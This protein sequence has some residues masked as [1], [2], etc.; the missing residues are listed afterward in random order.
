[1]RKRVC[2]AVFFSA[3]F[4]LPLWGVTI[5]VPGDYPTIQEGLNAAQTGDTVL[6][7]PGTYVE[8]IVWPSLDGIVLIS[9]EGAD[10]TI[11]D[12]NG[13]G[14]VITFPNFAF[15]QTTTIFGFT[16][17][18]GKLGTN[19]YGAG[20]YINGSPYIFEN[21][22]QRNIA[23]DTSSTSR[24]YGGGIYCNGAGTPLILANVIR[25][26]VVQ[27]SI[28]NYGG[29]IYVDDD[30]SAVIIGNTIE[31][32]SA[33]GGYYNYGA[34]I[35]CAIGSSPD[36]RHNII[37][38]N[39][40]YQGDRGHGVGIYVADDS[41]PYILSN[42]IY[43]N[44]AQSG[45]WNYGA[46]MLLNSGATVFNNTIAENKC[47]GGNWRYGGGI[48]LYDSTQTIGN[49]IVVNNT[50][51][52]GGGIYASTNGHA[53]LLNNDVWNN[54]G[55]NYSGIAPGANDISLDPLFVTGPLGNFY[56]SQIAAG[57]GQDSPCVD[58]GFASAES[59]ELN[60]YTTR[61]DTIPDSGMVDLGY[62]YP[63]SYYVT[64]EEQKAVTPT[65][66]F[67]VFPSL[68]SSSYR[69]QLMLDSNKYV[70]VHIFDEAGRLQRILFNGKLA[71]GKHYWTWNSL[72]K[73]GNRLPSGT[74]FFIVRVG[75]YKT[76]SK[77]VILL[78]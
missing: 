46:G 77:K 16:I 23:S 54:T 22:I 65:S 59:L 62:H 72:D 57:Q 27:S 49:N 52:S 26:N 20:L 67:Q 25:G 73:N 21:I 47:T 63:T 19:V 45:L 35:Y 6:V 43:N 15:T 30:N 42:L 17:Q 36:I 66:L 50:A 1:M 41:Y 14:R 60:T 11:I 48:F 8:N 61:T 32:D 39:V 12:G 40:A 10:T 76:F 68:S 33:I 71:P 74:Y 37:K 44:T 2:I 78:M 7:A 53:T 24:I 34:G 55:G 38:D 70:S 5:L 58:Y 64:V 28:R 3:V 9:E 56:L 69:V 18:N 75:D 13:S 29:G 31:S 51:G 4:A